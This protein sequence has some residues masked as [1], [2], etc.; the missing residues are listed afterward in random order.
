MAVRLTL[1][2]VRAHRVATHLGGDDVLD[3]GIQDTPPGT[4]AV[5][6]LAAR[7][8]SIRDGLVLVHAA[9]GAMHL[10]R[11]ADVAALTAALRPDDAADLRKQQFGPFFASLDRPIGAALDEVAD[12]MAAVM[13]D[14]VRR[15]KGA[16]STAVSA[17]VDQRL[18]PW[19]PGCGASHVD[20][21]LFRLA[22][23]PAGLRLVPNGDGSADFVAG[24]PPAPADRVGNGPTGL[25]AGPPLTEVDRQAAR[26][27]LVRRFLRYAG[28]TDR[29]G[30]AAWLG[31][32]PAAARRWWDGLADVVPVE[33]D[34]RRLFLHPDD[35]E[36]ARA[37]PR[38]H[39]VHLLPPHDPV[40]ELSDRRL[41]V[42][43]PAHRK[44][45]WRAAA[46]PGVVLADG[47]VA[48]IWRRRKG[49]ITVT[50]FGRAP[51]RRTLVEAAGEEVVVAES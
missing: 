51:G 6:A 27:E 11:A 25:A 9:R 19:C 8:L 23:L 38:A 33:V 3:T 21:A 7:G 47:A 13:S 1:A 42:P 20:D 35:V 24:P 36:A 26:R 12:A 41:L 40:L 16:L 14:G 10:H 2:E 28:P 45:V 48:G 22:S 18:R 34:G 37:A 5:L 4:T 17:A 31:L 39:G 29:D 43:D 30:L 32:S 15:G 50:P 44:Q 46:N 49:A